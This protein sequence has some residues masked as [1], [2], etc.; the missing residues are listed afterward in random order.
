MGIPSVKGTA[1]T[2]PGHPGHSDGGR[3]LS[4]PGVY[5][6]PRTTA[7]PDVPGG[8]ELSDPCGFKSFQAHLLLHYLPG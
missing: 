4:F 3:E 1:G 8:Y 2:A 5:S 6:Q 7:Q